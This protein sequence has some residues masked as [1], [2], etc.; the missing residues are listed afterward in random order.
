M[1]ATT[2]A[3]QGLAHD[4]E[5]YALSATRVRKSL[6]SESEPIFGAGPSASRRACR[7]SPVWR[8]MYREQVSIDLIILDATAWRRMR[9]NG[10]S[11]PGREENR[12]GYEIRRDL[13]FDHSQRSAMRRAISKIGDARRCVLSSMLCRAKS[14]T[15]NSWG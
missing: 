9:R 15:I 7:E 11:Q 5:F 8:S 13:P 14:T 3:R 12:I 2:V 4:A 10:T 6:G 1:T